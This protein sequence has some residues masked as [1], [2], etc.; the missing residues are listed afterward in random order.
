MHRSGTSCLTGLVQQCGVTL[1][2]VFTE[3]PHNRK[4]NR[5]RA[6]VQDLNEQLLVQNDGAWDRPVDAQQWSRELADR[7]DQ[8]IDD[9]RA[10][11]TPWWGFKDPRCLLTLAFWQQAI[12][13]PRY[14]GTYRHPHRVALS[15]HKRNEMPL[16]E[17]YQ[18]WCAY[19]S[20]LL[21][22]ARKH[23]FDLVNFDLDDEHYQLDVDKKL[24]SLGLVRR[25]D[26]SFFD[27]G[28]RNQFAINVA[29]VSLPAEAANLYRELKVL[30]GLDRSS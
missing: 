4:G 15:L 18:L 25:G 10:Q 9:L 28:L 8:I 17:A 5:E 22:F 6:D 12:D 20:R 23:E 29:D 24:T 19:N 3:N 13:E 14:I 2:D 1:G 27:N 21:A 7:R 26:E 11:A 30:S 16:P